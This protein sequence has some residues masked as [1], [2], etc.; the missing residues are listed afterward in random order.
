MMKIIL[1]IFPSMV[2][3]HDVS[4]LRGGEHKDFDAIV[5]CSIKCTALHCTALQCI[6][7]KLKIQR[8]N[9]SDLCFLASLLEKNAVHIAC[10]VGSARLGSKARLG[11]PPIIIRTT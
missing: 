7:I 11:V 3:N 8:R 1:S 2:E 4:A 6:L 10:E 5:T 9:G